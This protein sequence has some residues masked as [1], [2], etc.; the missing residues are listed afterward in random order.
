MTGNIRRTNNKNIRHHGDRNSIWT[1]TEWSFCSQQWPVSR[2]DGKKKTCS[3]FSSF[4]IF[5]LLKEQ[6]FSKVKEFK[7]EATIECFTI[8]CSLFVYKRDDDP[9][10]ESMTQSRMFSIVFSGICRYT[11]YYI[12]LFFFFFIKRHFLVVWSWDE[13]ISAISSGERCSLKWKRYS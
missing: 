9:M 12:L 4:I 13:V 1:C 2:E 8:L 11:I 3:F 7:G 10:E 6:I 5:L